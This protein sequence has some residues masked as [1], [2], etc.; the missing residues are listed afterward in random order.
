MTVARHEVPGK[1]LPKEPSRRVRY[2]RALLIPEIVLVESASRRMFELLFD[3]MDSV[4][5][6]IDFLCFHNPN[7]VISILQSPNRSARTCKNQTVPYGTA[8]FGVA[9]S[10]HFVPGY[11]RT[12]PPGQKPFAYGKA[13]LS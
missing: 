7:F 13:S 3:V 1:R 12:V 6:H 9:R 11:D 10:R 2:E 4:P 8:P 5:E